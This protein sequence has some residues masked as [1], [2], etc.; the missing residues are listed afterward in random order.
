MVTVLRHKK[1]ALSFK[2]IA[3]NFEEGDEYVLDLNDR[4]LFEMTEGN[5][6]L[7]E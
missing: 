3:I 2:V 7:L 1:D 6:Y 5:T 4:D